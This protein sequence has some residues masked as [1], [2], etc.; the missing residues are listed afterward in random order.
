MK[1]DDLSVKEKKNLVLINLVSFDKI[2]WILFK[3]LCKKKQTVKALIS[4]GS[5]VSFEWPP[6]FLFLK[7]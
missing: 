3:Y 7:S 5:H 2:F 6:G 1:E 4:V